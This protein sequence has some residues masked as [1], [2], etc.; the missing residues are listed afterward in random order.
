MLAKMINPNR[1]SRECQWNLMCCPRCC[2]QSDPDQSRSTKRACKS[3]LGLLAVHGRTRPEICRDMPAESETGKIRIAEMKGCGLYN[4]SGSDL[5][6]W[7]DRQWQPQSDLIK[8]QADLVA[9]ARQAQTT[10]KAAKKQGTHL[11]RTVSRR[12]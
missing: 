3:D 2:L 12:R 7:E 4:K 8:I 5:Q 9:R 11:G 6:I 10:L 1:N